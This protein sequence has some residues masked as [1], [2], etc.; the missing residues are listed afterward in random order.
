MKPLFPPVGNKAAQGQQGGI[1]VTST[2]EQNSEHD[3]AQ[4]TF[5]SDLMHAN[6]TIYHRRLP[7]ICPVCWVF[8]LAPVK[9]TEDKIL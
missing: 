1:G 2:S 5:A 6:V 3:G 4:A 8:N 9:R 7:L